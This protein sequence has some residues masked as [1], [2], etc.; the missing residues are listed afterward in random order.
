M[1]LT[2]V[3][4]FLP[5]SDILLKWGANFRP[6]TL[7]GQWW[8]L[9]SNCFLHIGVLHLLMNMYALMFIGLLLEPYLGRT[10]LLTAY[11]LTG[12]VA[13]TTSLLWHPLTISAGASGA[14]FGLYGVFLAMLTTN[15]IEKTARKALLTS[16]VI[17]VGYNLMNGLKEGIDNAAHLGGLIA[18]IGFGYAYVP[19]LKEPEI[20]EIRYKA[21][22]Y[23]SVLAI[24]FT[25]VSYKNLPND[26]SKYENTM[27]KFAETEARALEFYKMPGM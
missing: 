8:R 20:P 3:N 1:A 21:I 4:I 16:I 12:L 11:F 27:K 6:A 15:L 18:G 22:M 23:M 9:I 25:I 7:D 26:F 5:D 24:A 2:G 17:F 19:G 10:G 13:S 14:I